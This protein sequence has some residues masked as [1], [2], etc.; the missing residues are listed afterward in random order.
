MNDTVGIIS[1]LLL[2]NNEDVFIK[3]VCTVR[4]R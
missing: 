4:I 3:T 2:A 1:G